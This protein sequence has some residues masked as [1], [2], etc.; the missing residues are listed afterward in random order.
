M[1][2]ADIHAQAPPGAHRLA[3]SRRAALAV[4]AVLAANTVG[5][6][7]HGLLA[8]R[9]GVAIDFVAFAGASRLLL[10]GS[11]CLYCAVPLHAAESAYLGIPQAASV[12][13]RNPPL[14]ALVLAP[15]AAL[16]ATLGLVAFLILSLLAVGAGGWL[17]VTRLGCPW[18]TSILAVLSLPA[19]FGLAEGQWDPLLFLA[20]VAALVL[21]DRCP[22]VAGLLLSMLAIKVQALWL[23]PVALLAMRRWRVL[24][25]MGIGAAVLGASAVA[26]LGPHL[27]DWPRAVLLAGGAQNAAAVGPAGIA[28][29]LWGSGAGFVAFGVGGVIAVVAT[30]ALRG[31]LRQDPTLA[32]AAAALLSL[33]LSPHV[34]VTDF[35]L[36]APALALAGR[37]LPTSTAVAA[38]LLSLGYAVG[39]LPSA[40][41]DLDASIPAFLAATGVVLIVLLRRPR[42]RGAAPATSS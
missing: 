33:L 5:E 2:E 26:L 17:L 23:V 10:E 15:L 42:A 28:A 4:G 41:L 21:L 16:P 8:M 22:L 7:I 34:W 25:G 31:R 37:R 38:V 1:V 6:G 12:P 35:L 14:A 18:W 19:A 13:F 27:L 29:S 36:L 20:L 30:M 3:I 24:L 40:L 11:Q 9:S 39:S 32:V